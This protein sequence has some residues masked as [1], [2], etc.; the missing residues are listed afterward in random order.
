MIV[1]NN[2]SGYARFW[3]SGAMKFFR[4]TGSVIRQNTTIGGDGPGIW[5]DWEHYQN[6]LEEEIFLS[7]R[8]GLESELR[9]RQGRTS[10][11]TTWQSTPNPVVR[12]SSMES[13]RGAAP[14][15]G[16]FQMRF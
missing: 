1:D 4:L 16:L 5:L 15:S 3:E 8:Q 11:P 14:G 12:G 2:R 6:R 7:V 13:W 9:H 10:S